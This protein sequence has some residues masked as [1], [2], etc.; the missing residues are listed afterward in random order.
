MEWKWCKLSG[1]IFKQSKE[2]QNKSWIS[3]NIQLLQTAVTKIILYSFCDDTLIKVIIMYSKCRCRLDRW[4]HFMQQHTTITQSLMFICAW[5]TCST[6]D[7]EFGSNHLFYYIHDKLWQALHT[8]KFHFQKFHKNRNFSYNFFCN[9]G[10]FP[11][12][13]H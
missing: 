1:L 9:L 10:E 6:A 3:S 11:W 13:Q 2:K 7:E 5:K 8:D 12:L 4:V